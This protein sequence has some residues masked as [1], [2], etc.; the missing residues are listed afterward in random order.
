MPNISNCC[1][2]VPFNHSYCFIQAF[3]SCE[4]W[5]CWGLGRGCVLEGRAQEAWSRPTPGSP[6]DPLIKLIRNFEKDRGRVVNQRF[7]IQ[8][9]LVEFDIKNTF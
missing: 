6:L 3:I 9:I 2:I 4:P 1:Q 7:S 5:Y 8:R